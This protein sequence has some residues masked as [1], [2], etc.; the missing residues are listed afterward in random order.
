ML[1]SL[2]PARDY[3]S[4]QGAAASATTEIMERYMSRE[5][6]HSSD[7]Y[8]DLFENHLIPELRNACRL[9]KKLADVWCAVA[10][11]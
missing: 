3:A 1:V 2:L 6:T 10:A 7:S 4:Q 5:L 9:S 8:C 11:Q